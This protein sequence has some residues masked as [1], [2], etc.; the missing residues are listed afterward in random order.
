MLVNTCREE[1]K[2]RDRSISLEI[3]E[4]LLLSIIQ[5]GHVLVKNVHPLEV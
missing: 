5:G 1:G 4:I 3:S 2:E